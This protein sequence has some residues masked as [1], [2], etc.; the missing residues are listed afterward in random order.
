MNLNQ[1]LQTKLIKGAYKNETLYVAQNNRCKSIV[2]T[3]D[4]IRH[5]EAHLSDHKAIAEFCINN[6]ITQHTYK[7]IVIKY[8][9]FKS[10]ELEGNSETRDF[11]VSDYNTLFVDE[12]ECVI[13]GF[14]YKLSDLIN[15]IN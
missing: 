6:N 9:I 1:F 7:K 15:V 8:N 13:E 14:G 12:M 10:I 4:I 2:N 5:K 3:I 11:K